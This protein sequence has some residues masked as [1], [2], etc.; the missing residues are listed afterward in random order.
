M[1]GLDAE[2]RARQRSCERTRSLTSIPVI[3]PI[4]AS[5]IAAT[6]PDVSVFRSGRQFATWLGL[7]SSRWV[8][9]L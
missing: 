9:K 7:A 3:G 6:V 2:I 1:D 8:A 5:A 4:T